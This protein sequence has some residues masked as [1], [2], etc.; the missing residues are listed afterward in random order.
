MAS[1]DLSS[2]NE[3]DD[4]V[5]P[6]QAQPSPLD[7]NDP[8]AALTPEET[9]DF[10]SRRIVVFTSGGDAPG[11]NSAVRAVVATCITF[12][13]KV[14][15]ARNGYKGLVEGGDYLVEMTRKDIEGIMGIGGTVIGSARCQEFRTIE[16]RLSACENLIKLGVTGLIPIG[17]D[18]TLTGA[19]LFKDEWPT[20]TQQ[21]LKAGRITP[22]QHDAYRSLALVGMVGS[23]D[24]D[25]CGFSLT[26]GV[27]TALHRIMEAIDALITT[28]RSHE[29]TFVVE[30]MGRNCGYL[31]LAAALACGA[32]WVFLPEMPPDLEDWESAMCNS[33][34]R[35]RSRGYSL[36]ILAEGATDR[37]RRPIAADYLRD[38]LA[39]RLGFDTRITTLGHVQRGGAPSALDRILATRLGIDAAL[40]LLRSDP[41]NPGPGRIVGIQ[42]NSLV[43]LDIT[44]SVAATRRIGT[45][46][47]ERRFAE[48]IRLRGPT[49]DRHVQVYLQSRKT[50]LPPRKGAEQRIAIVC[51]GSPAAGIN[52]AVRTTVRL[53]LNHGH[54]PLGVAEGWKGLALGDM[55]AMTWGEVAGWNALAGCNLGTRRGLPTGVPGGIA[56]IAAQLEKNEVHGLIVIGGFDAFIGTAQLFEAREDHPKLQIPL[57]V[58]PAT[59]SNNVPGSDFSLGSDTALNCIV[60]SIDRLKQSAESSRRRVF[61]VEVMGGYCGYLATVGGLAGGADD[62]YT[63]EETLHMADLQDT[64]DHFASKFN[65]GFNQALVV[66]NELCSEN[67]TTTFLS[68]LFEEEGK[69]ATPKYTVRSNI[70]G[71]L[72][73][74][75]TPSPL[76]RLRGTSLA[77][78]AVAFIE[79]SVQAC[80]Q[81]DGSVCACTPASAGVVGIKEVKGVELLQDL[82]PRSDFSHRL[83]GDQW[84][85]PL[86]PLMR[87]LQGNRKF[88]KSESLRDLRST[89]RLVSAGPHGHFFDE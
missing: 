31:A 68:S 20:L 46:L 12:G 67:F 87:L 42:Y 5:S 6:P 8:L 65:A 64:V 28:A 10:A 4:V 86:L 1:S 55:H 89:A 26:I 45:L 56:A 44:E 43:H 47:E 37:V 85:R 27:D 61:I 41:H 62:A 58:V 81:P 9:A 75:R 84:S 18:G 32:D 76:D 83:P 14:F 69:T 74:G 59:I 15:A 36:V 23:I 40:T 35:R 70:L 80:M 3:G 16:G 54:V 24:N 50:R 63:W 49:F 48:A 82:I 78:G 77:A 22:E 72:Q 53:L 57:C 79:E 7:P 39:T 13:A 34:S 21:L 52:A 88:A 66:R 33:L 73:Q 19:N 51:V 2:I 60:D 30:V 25:M 29:R 71:H 38:V 17:G 11:M